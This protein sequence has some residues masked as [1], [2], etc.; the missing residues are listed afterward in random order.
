MDVIMTE[1]SASGADLHSLFQKVFH[2]YATL[3][4]VEDGI[5]EQ[6]GMRTPHVKLA[7]TILSQG[8][9]TVP[10]VAYA[11][12]VSRQFVQTAVNELEKQGV[13]VFLE[14]PRHKR[15]K[16]LQLTEYG[17]KKLEQTHKNEAAL[18]QQILPNLNKKD[19]VDARNVLESILERMERIP[20]ERTG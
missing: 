4:E 1:K 15:S 19:V 8:Q 2:L 14:N 5:H 17:Q 11:M 3:S 18:I 10:D 9:A 7:K 13:L 20:S 16:L 12:K 6:A